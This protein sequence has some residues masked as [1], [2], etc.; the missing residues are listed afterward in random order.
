MLANLTLKSPFIRLL[1]FGPKHLWSLIRTGKFYGSLRLMVEITGICTLKCPL[2]YQRKRYDNRELTDSEWEIKIKNILRKKPEILGVVWLGG[3]P[4][5]RFELVKKLSKYFFY[6]VICTNGTLPLKKIKNTVY[7]VSVDGTKEFYEKQRGQ[8]YEKVKKNVELSP[9]N[10]LTIIC[11]LSK[12]NYSCIKQ[13]VTEW[14]ALPTVGKIIFSFY[15]PNFKDL[16][17]NFWLNEDEKT[18]IIKEVGCLAIKYPEQLG[19]TARMLRAYQ[20]RDRQNMSSVCHSS[21]HLFLSSSGDPVYHK[22]AKEKV[23][24]G[25]PEADCNKCGTNYFIKVNY[26]KQKSVGIIRQY[27]LSRISSK[28]N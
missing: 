13:F 2:C 18:L 24:C 23:M 5:L 12:I 15:T 22:H 14:T 3:E 16:S 21:Q 9:K 20:E 8:N 28:I 10:N 25:C 26:A 19:E 7:W 11:L 17:N 1:V 27:L 4:M 6:N